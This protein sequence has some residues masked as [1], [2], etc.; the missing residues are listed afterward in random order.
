M[1]APLPPDPA[2]RPRSSPGSPCSCP[3]CCCRLPAQAANRATP[4][5][6]HRLRL[7]PVRDPDPVGHG[8]L[9]AQLAVLGGRHLHL[10]RLPRL[11]HPAQPDPDAGSRPSSRNGWRLLPITLGPAGLLQPALPALQRR[12]AVNPSPTNNYAAARAP[13]PRRGR[14]RRRGREAAGHRR[15][16]ARS[17]TT[18]RP[19][20]S[21]TPHCRESALHFTS[22]WTAQAARARLRLRRLLQRRRPASRPSTTPASTGPAPSPSPTGSGSRAGTARPTPRR[23][24]IRSDGWLPGGRMKQYLGGHN[25]T[26]GGVTINIDSQLARPR[27]GLG[28]ARR[29]GPLRR[30]TPQL[31]QLPAARSGDTGRQVRAAQCLL[32]RRGPLQRSDGR[33]HGRRGDGRGP[34]LARGQPDAGRPLDRRRGCGSALHATDS[35]QLIKVGAA[36]RAGA[37]AAA[38]AQRGSSDDRLSYAVSSTGRRPP[39]VK[40]YQRRAGLPAERRGHPLQT[41]QSKLDRGRHLARASA[42]RAPNAERGRGLRRGRCGRVGV[43]AARRVST[44]RVNERVCVRRPRCVTVRA[45][46]RCDPAPPPVRRASSQRARERLDVAGRTA[47]SARPADSENSATNGS[48]G[49]GRP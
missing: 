24:Y 15:R 10:R 48:P 36:R 17:G 43:Q 38:G 13:G 42:C 40:G 4:R 25:E 12:R 22:A 46:R 27:R 28:G 9:A 8:R 31:P 5:Q 16:A 20:T 6:L 1:S 2:R 26:W 7:R 11:P 47:T 34:R 35:A 45:C 32:E 37:P 29:A 41:W 33:D 18:W 39:S 49:D 44:G 19:T 21:A 3:R 30:R 23:R 14:R